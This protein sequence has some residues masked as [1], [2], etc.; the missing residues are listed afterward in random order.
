MLGGTADVV[1]TRQ[2]ALG[3][4]DEVSGRA[5]IGGDGLQGLDVGAVAGLGHAETT[6]H[7]QV[8]QRDHILLVMGCRTQV[9]DRATKQAPLHARLDHQR[10]VRV[11]DRPSSATRRFEVRTSGSAGAVRV[12]MDTSLAR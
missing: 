9:F 7:I 8:D 11:A 6:E 4:E 12:S 5:V 2:R 1:L 10:Q 3:V